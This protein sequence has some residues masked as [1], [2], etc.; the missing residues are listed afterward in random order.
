MTKKQILELRP[1]FKFGGMSMIDWFE[2]NEGAGFYSIRS[3]LNHAD[4]E[5]K[6]PYY[7]N[8]MLG[9]KNAEKKVRTEFTNWWKELNSVKKKDAVEEA[10]KMLNIPMDT[11]PPLASEFLDYLSS[12]VGGCIEVCISAYVIYN[13]MV[14]NMECKDDLYKTTDPD[15][16]KWW[17]EKG[18]KLKE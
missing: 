6:S 5:T 13:Q 8:Y 17:E 16:L 15:I 1:Q 14:L 10:L 18:Y 11:L 3:G 12:K 2:I 4:G 9:G 7:F